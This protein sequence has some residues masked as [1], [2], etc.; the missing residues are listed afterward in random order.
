MLHKLNKRAIVVI[1]AIVAI[2]AV[3]GSS[4]AWFVT[5][6][7]LLQNINLAGIDVSADVFFVDGSNTKFSADEFKDKVTGVGI[8]EDQINGSYLSDHYPVW[9]DI[10][11]EA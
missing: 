8:W 11:I 6:S 5:R 10:E 4:F 9:M 2:I 1:V 3:V 7:S